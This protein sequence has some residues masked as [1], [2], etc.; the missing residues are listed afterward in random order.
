MLALAD[1]AGVSLSISAEGTLKAKG[2]K[3]A[4]GPSCSADQGTQ[5][6][7]AC[8]YEGVGAEAGQRLLRL[9]ARRGHAEACPA[10]MVP[11]KHGQ[12]ERLSDMQIQESV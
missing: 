2:G 11:A 10:G 7:A 6:R 8:V 5:G 3:E 1:Q 4:G 12:V 9:S